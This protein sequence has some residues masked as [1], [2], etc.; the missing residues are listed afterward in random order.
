MKTISATEAKNNFGEILELAT[1][2][3]VGIMKN[4]RA[5]AVILSSTEFSQVEG[6]LAMAKA[7]AGLADKEEWVIAPLVAYSKLEISSNEATKRLKLKYRGQLL[8]LLGMTDL[9]FPSLPSEQTEAMMH[10][11]VAGI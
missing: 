5:V 8:D 3:P 9:S 1:I 4:G 10:E 6:D 11:L 7:K 2:A